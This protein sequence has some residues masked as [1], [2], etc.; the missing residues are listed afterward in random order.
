MYC[1]R[2]LCTISGEYLPRTDVSYDMFVDADG[3]ILDAPSTVIIYATCPVVVCNQMYGCPRLFFSP[4]E[5]L[6]E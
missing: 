4:E 6:Y 2:I 3:P 5:F 1:V